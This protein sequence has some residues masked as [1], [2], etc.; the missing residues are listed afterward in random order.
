MGKNRQK[1][2]QSDASDEEAAGIIVGCSSD[3]EWLLPW[4][5]MNFRL[6]NPYPVT[7]VDF[8]DLSDTA[9]EW[10]KKRGKVASLDIDI[11]FVTG[12]EGIDSTLAKIW[13]GINP[14]V[15]KVRLSWF[16]KPFAFLKSPY[17][18]TVWIDLD[19]QVRGSLQPLF[20][21]LVEHEVAIVPEQEN[22][23]HLEWK[24]LLPGEVMYNSGVI[25][26]RRNS[27]LI[28]EWARRSIDQNHLF[29]GD[30]QLLTRLIFK[31]QLAVAP[32]PTI[33][34]WPILYGTN[35]EAII[36][37]WWGRYKMQIVL[38]CDC[39]QKYFYINLAL[40]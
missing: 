6:H 17:K 29:I 32:M 26:F 38:Q 3:Q 8:G 2:K 33:Y 7:F 12:K 22:P 9:T 4:W 21:A 20:D 34:N 10:C 13:E 11:S 14:S 31:H 25:A 27:E 40:Q 37:H 24:L 30:Q 18:K 39:L 19:C 1:E 35:P 15:W 23:L 16:K 5:W 36:L 28:E